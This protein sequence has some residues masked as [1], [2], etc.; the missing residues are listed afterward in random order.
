LGVNWTGSK[1]VYK[2]ALLRRAIERPILAAAFSPQ[3][4]RFFLLADYFFLLTGAFY[5]IITPAIFGPP[6]V[7]A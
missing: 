5:M 4:K 6:T 2:V 1:R 7:L 3:K